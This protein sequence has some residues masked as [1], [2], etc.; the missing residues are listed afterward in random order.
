MKKFFIKG[1]HNGSG[2]K[3]VALNC[4]KFWQIMAKL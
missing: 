4:N 2:S 1:M 3:T